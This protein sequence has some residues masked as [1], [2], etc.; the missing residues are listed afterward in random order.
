MRRD[1]QL[2]KARGC[3]AGLALGDAMGCPTEFM[4]PEQIAAEY[5]WVE[6]LVAAP[7]WHP[8]AALPAGRVTD[9]TEQAMALAGVYLRDGRMSAEA[10]A[11]AV[12]DWADAQGEH[13]ALYLGP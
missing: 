12:L 4:T 8:H 13:L 1:S 3:L 7:I 10:M 9:D 6:G 5:G 2:G 11:Q